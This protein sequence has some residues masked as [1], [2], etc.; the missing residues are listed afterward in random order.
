MKSLYFS[1]NFKKSSFLPAYTGMAI[2]GWIGR[3]DFQMDVAIVCSA[4]EEMGESGIEKAEAYAQQ[5]KQGGED[6]VFVLATYN[7][8]RPNWRFIGYDV[9]ELPN[10]NWSAVEMHEAYMSNEDFSLWSLKLNDHGLFSH[11]RDAESLLTFYMQS[12]DPDRG[13]HRPPERSIPDEEY[14][15]VPV[16]RY[17]P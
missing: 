6:W 8:C 10:F 13:Y 4:I 17:D 9:C 1:S 5:L 14:G 11:Q 7:P 3:N 12:E 16:W 2:S 15:V